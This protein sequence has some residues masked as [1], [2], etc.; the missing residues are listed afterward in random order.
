MANS[1]ISNLTV[2]NTD[3]AQSKTPHDANLP[4]SMMILMRRM[5]PFRALA[6]KSFSSVV[7]KRTRNMMIRFEKQTKCYSTQEGK[8]AE[9]LKKETK[10]K[11][12]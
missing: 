5:E 2:M 9:E 8:N 6:K 10:I 7:A 1:L 12:K 11:N 4:S 3:E